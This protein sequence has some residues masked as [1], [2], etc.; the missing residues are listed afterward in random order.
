MAL[1]P[2]WNPGKHKELLYKPQPELFEIIECAMTLAAIRWP[3]QLR[4]EK[5]RILGAFDM[6]RRSAVANESMTEKTEKPIN[7]GEGVKEKEEAAEKPRR[8]IHV[9]VDLRDRDRRLTSSVHAKPAL[10]KSTTPATKKTTK[11][12]NAGDHRAQGKEEAVEKPSRTIHVKVDLLDRDR[13]LTSGSAKPALQLCQTGAIS[14]TEK[15]V[16][17][18]PNRGDE[19]KGEYERR[20]EITKRKLQSGYSACEESRKRS[21]VID[22]WTEVPKNTQQQILYDKDVPSAGRFNNNNKIQRCRPP[23]HC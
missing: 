4:A 1:P 20:L 10:Q 6:S 16:S 3:K 7:A 11:P 17:S 23:I 21:K 5:A 2:C 19:A 12:I 22:F 18:E 15:R 9:E 14:K 13:K 8:S